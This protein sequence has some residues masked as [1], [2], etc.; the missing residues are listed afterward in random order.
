LPAAVSL[1][2]SRPTKAVSAVTVMKGVGAV[3]HSVRS[4]KP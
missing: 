3:Q 2:A 4:G 1:S